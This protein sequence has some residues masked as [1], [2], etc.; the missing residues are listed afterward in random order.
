MPALVCEPAV[1]EARSGLA[2]PQKPGYFAWSM[3]KRGKEKKQSKKELRAQRKAEEEAF[4]RE[5]ERLMRRRR[6]IVTAIPLLTVAIAAGLYWGMNEPRLTGFAILG[7]AIVWLLVAT[8]VVGSTV[9][10]RDRLA[11][12]NISYGTSDKRP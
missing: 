1:G 7:G 2:S 12:G 6:V 8:G 3:G 9:P 11:A 10:K 4:E 5:M